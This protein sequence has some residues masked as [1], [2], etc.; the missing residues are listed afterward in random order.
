MGS[1]ARGTHCI[2]WS[3]PLDATVFFRRV[4]FFCRGLAPGRSPAA[5]HHQV[6]SGAIA[7]GVV[8]L[9][10]AGLPSVRDQAP[11]PGKYSTE[12]HE[13]RESRCHPGSSFPGNPLFPGS[14]TAA[15][16]PQNLAAAS[17]FRSPIAVPALGKSRAMSTF[18]SYEYFF[19]RSLNPYPARPAC[20][21]TWIFLATCSAGM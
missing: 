5:P 4:P 12:R 7:A 21:R 15:S 13:G 16:C 9:T 14:L 18:R 10:A 19:P 11:A 1:K 2:V 20:Y 8:F 6:R 3:F 17:N